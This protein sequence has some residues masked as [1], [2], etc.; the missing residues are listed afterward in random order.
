VKVSFK[1]VVRRVEGLVRASAELKGANYEKTEN[2]TKTAYRVR[3]EPGE[4][5]D[6]PQQK[7]LRG[8]EKSLGGKAGGEWGQ[9]GGSGGR[10]IWSAPEDYFR[11]FMKL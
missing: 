1:P 7:N 8:A 3:V 5:E 10:N 2:C 9:G 6:I 11:S 4:L